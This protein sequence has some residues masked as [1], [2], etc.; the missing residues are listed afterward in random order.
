MCLTA[1]NPVRAVRFLTRDAGIRQFLDI[2]T[3]LPTAEER[4]NPAPKPGG[5]THTWC[6]PA[7]TPP[8]RGPTA[9][10]AICPDQ[11]MAGSLVL[12]APVSRWPARR[13]TWPSG[14][15]TVTSYQPWA[16][17]VLTVCVTWAPGRRLY[18]FVAWWW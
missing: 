10:C 9:S 14:A 5:S 16:A 18:V 15:V 12:A 2:G 7:R 6:V 8:A 11:P 4:R 3:G 17:D 1:W 13:R